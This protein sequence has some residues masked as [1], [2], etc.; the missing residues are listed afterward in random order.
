MIARVSCHSLWEKVLKKKKKE[1]KKIF[2]LT[3]F[4]DLKKKH[5]FL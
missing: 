5:E 3:F 4:Y 2:M 1:D